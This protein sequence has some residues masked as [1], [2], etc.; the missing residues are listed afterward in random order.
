MKTAQVVVALYKIRQM[1]K[2]VSF[3]LFLTMLLPNLKAQVDSALGPHEGKIKIYGNY[4]VEVI[5]CNDYLEIY[6]YDKNLNPINNDF[7][8]EGAAKFFYYNE[9]NSTSA[10]VHY[11]ADGFTA[12]IST[13]DYMYCQITATINGQVITAKFENEC[14]VPGGKK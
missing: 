4:R 14:H 12:K 8:I 10:F 1:K 5:G 2:S 7:G 11:G 13:Q 6:F 9:T 3:L